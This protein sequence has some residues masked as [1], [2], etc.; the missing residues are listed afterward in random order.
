M[1]CTAL[2]K[3][4]KNCRA[5]AY[6]FLHTCE[7]HSSKEDILKITISKNISKILTKKLL[8]Y[9]RWKKH[10]E[11]CINKNCVDECLDDEFHGYGDNCE[12][13]CCECNKCGCDYDL[14]SCDECGVN[15]HYECSDYLDISETIYNIKNINTRSRSIFSEYYTVYDYT[16]YKE[17]GQYCT[18]CTE[19][20]A[21]KFEK[22]S[23]RITKLEEQLLEIPLDFELSNKNIELYIDYNVDIY[24]VVSS[25]SNEFLI[26]TE[27]HRLISEELNFD[28]EIFNNMFDTCSMIEQYSKDCSLKIEK[29][30]TDYDDKKQRFIE[31]NNEMKKFD[32]EELEFDDEKFNRM[33]KKDV[34]IEK[35][36]KDLSLEIVD[37]IVAYK[38][39][40]QRFI[41]INNEMK[42]IDTICHSDE[43]DF[44]EYRTCDKMIG[45]NAI[46]S[47]YSNDL[48]DTSRL[49]KVNWHN[50]MI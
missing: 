23:D 6:M 46:I 42:K 49:H 47:N 31:I 21:D 30:V 33:I 5:N 44:F 20:V 40:K 32:S 39:K 24:E 3:K 50:L 13:T 36:Y 14:I 10:N 28:D 38:H 27:R 48:S 43:L 34:M 2:T 4:N 45:K 9:D 19:F 1:K 11:K 37:L 25:I 29:L 18:T 26:F 16:V 41:E 8:V 35:Y 22:I 12:I 17:G 15:I 7:A